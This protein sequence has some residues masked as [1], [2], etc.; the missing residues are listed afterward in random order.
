MMNF[1]TYNPLIYSAFM[2]ML[3]AQVAKVILILALEKRLALD[4]LTE[5]GGMP[6]SHSAAVAALSTACG[7]QYGVESPYF[8]IAIVFGAIVIYDATGVRRAAG[9]H[10]EILNS[11][12]VELSHLFEEGN[13]PK[14]LKTL[15]G[16]TYPQVFMG[17]LLGVVVGFLC[18]GSL[19]LTP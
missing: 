2:G 12:I 19:N 13:S 10:A 14:A 9:R 6:S 16:H 5:T 15:L 11:L 18:M 17:T 1:L 3:V 4:R 8:A 7:I